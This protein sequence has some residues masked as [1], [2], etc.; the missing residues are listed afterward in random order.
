[1]ESF[2]KR[3]QWKL[4]NATCVRK[5][6][7]VIMCLTAMKQLWRPTVTVETDVETM[8]TVCVDCAGLKKVL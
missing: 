5:C 3:T 4:S 7:A 8:L 2:A 1:M 6:S